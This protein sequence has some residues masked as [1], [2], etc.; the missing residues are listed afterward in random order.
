[1]CRAYRLLGT[2]LGALAAAVIMIP[3]LSNY[4]N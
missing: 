4:S 3:V 2:F 1:M